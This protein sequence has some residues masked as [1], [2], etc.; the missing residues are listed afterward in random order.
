VD[1]PKFT[2]DART[3]A[4]DPFLAAPHD[5]QDERPC[6]CIDGWHFIG[7]MVESADDPDGEVEVYERIPCKKYRGWA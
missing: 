2:R 7:Y 3:M 1:R 4:G 6:S 5:D